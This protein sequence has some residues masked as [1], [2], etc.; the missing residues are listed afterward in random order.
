MY[1]NEELHTKIYLSSEA[2]GLVMQQKL[3]SFYEPHVF[4]CYDDI[5]SN[6]EDET[7]LTD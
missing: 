7:S 4:N 6:E 5:W 3:E 1:H 2:H